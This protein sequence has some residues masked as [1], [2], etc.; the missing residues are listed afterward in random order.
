VEVGQSWPFPAAWGRPTAAEIPPEAL[1]DNETASRFLAGWAT[2]KI[3]QQQRR[4]RLTG[5]EA[6]Q[7]IETRIR[8]ENRLRLVEVIAKACP[9]A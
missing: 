4:R 6:L 7:Q 1:H 3:R 5:R 8:N 9:P 2:A